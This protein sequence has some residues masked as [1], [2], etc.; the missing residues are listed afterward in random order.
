[1]QTI[2]VQELAAEQQLAC[3]GM[4]WHELATEQQLA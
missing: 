3:I 1:M 4:S 2:G